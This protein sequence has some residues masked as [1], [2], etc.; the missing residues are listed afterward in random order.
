MIFMDGVKLERVI[1]ECVD[2]S[3]KDGYET[4]PG[5]RQHF[6][7]LTFDSPVRNVDGKLRVDVSPG[8][9]RVFEVQPVSGG[10]L[11]QQTRHLVLFYSEDD[12]AKGHD[13][14]L[15]LLIS[16]LIGASAML[17][18]RGLDVQRIPMEALTPGDQTRRETLQELRARPLAQ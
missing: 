11:D 12:K 2:V 7:L 6:L 15:N 4:V 5:K 9:E 3:G 18:L 14:E 17:E 10:S 13:I 16:K 1:R 8:I